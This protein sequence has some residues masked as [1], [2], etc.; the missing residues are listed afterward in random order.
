M[1]LLVRKFQTSNPLFQYHSVI[2][3]ENVNSTKNFNQCAIDPVNCIIKVN[4]STG[5]EF[6]APHTSLPVMQP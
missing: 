5:L 6:M 4:A 1:S 2:L 3:G